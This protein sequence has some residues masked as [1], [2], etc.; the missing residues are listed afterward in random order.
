MAGTSASPLLRGSIAA[1]QGM[2]TP[3]I[4]PRTPRSSRGLEKGG[5]RQHP[6][7][8]RDRGSHQGGES[9][10]VERAE[11]GVRAMAHSSSC[12]L[13]K[14]RPWGA[15]RPT[16]ATFVTCYHPLF[17]FNQFGDWEGAVRP[18]NVQAPT[19]ASRARPGVEL[20]SRCRLCRRGVE[21][22]EAQS[23]AIRPRQRRGREPTSSSPG[24]YRPPKRPIIFYL[25]PVSG[26]DRAGRRWNSSRV[27]L[28]LD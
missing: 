25:L 2:K 20:P 12:Q 15:V 7:P 3:T 16:T 5:G 23:F 11:P 14:P 24:S 4:W 26:C 21:Y 19:W 10:G 17:C 28:D 18:G 27:L 13:G 9:Q 1:W 8:V 22:L 6:E